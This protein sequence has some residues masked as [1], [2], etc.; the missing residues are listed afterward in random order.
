M[1]RMTDNP[2]SGMGRTRFLLSVLLPVLL[3]V[4]FTF[5]CVAGLLYLSAEKS[6]EQASAREIT[7]VRHFLDR[8][9]EALRQI[10]ANVVGWDD[11]LEAV[12]PPFDKDWVASNLGE[13]LYEN[14]GIDM[15]FL[16]DASL[17]PVFAMHRG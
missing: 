16:L 17:T 2:Q 12:T 3:S 7:L 1:G 13:D 11:A 8:Q 6:D 4:V 14:D 10:Q 5:S 9:Q 15:V